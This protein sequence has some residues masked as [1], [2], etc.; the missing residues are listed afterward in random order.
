MA[1][2]LVI[3]ASRS[4]TLRQLLDIGFNCLPSNKEFYLEL[5]KRMKIEDEK[6]I[7]DYETVG[8]S[9]FEKE[10]LFLVKHERKTLNYY[11]IAIYWTQKGDKYILYCVSPHVSF[12]FDSE[13]RK[14]YNTLDEL[15]GYALT[16]VHSYNVRNIEGVKVGE[17]KV[18]PQTREILEVMSSRQE[19]EVNILY[20]HVRKGGII[21]IK[22]ELSNL[23][24]YPLTETY[25]GF[26]ILDDDKIV[27]L[28]YSHCE[29]PKYSNDCEVYA[30][31]YSCDDTKLILATLTYNEG[32]YEI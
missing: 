21:K 1:E 29:E 23:S 11:N 6:T 7:K 10:I 17:D 31:Q 32:S 18:P 15:I 16:V 28:G 19:N 12:Y 14:E 3:Q 25:Q 8:W 26:L 30:N 2:S 13:Q 27:I 22:Y 4:F 20:E 9:L 5:L 24:F